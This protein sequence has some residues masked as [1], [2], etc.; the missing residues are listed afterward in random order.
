[1]TSA[2]I[3]Y[4]PG[5]SEHDLRLLGVAPGHRMLDLGDRSP[6]AAIALAAGG[7]HVIAVR[8]TAA[9]ITAGQ[10]ATTAARVSVE[11]YE[12]DRAELAF[13]RAESIDAVVA[14]DGFGR[15]DD[16]DRV[17]RS[18]HRVL[19]PEAPLVFTLPHPMLLATEAELGGGTGVTATVARD[20]ADPTPRTLPPPEEAL[21]VHP[22]TIA[23]VFASLQR[24]GFRVD[25]VLEPDDPDDPSPRIP[26]I[27]IF[28]G[29]KLGN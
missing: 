2:T 1:M 28:R 14:V 24:A 3:Q 26:P 12:A 27:V 8:D 29:R 11:W 19:K 22:H 7:A 6:D 21:T 4:G 15:A 13:C 9:G 16:L 18:A 10:A 17:L 20:Y 23:E 25:Q 5:A